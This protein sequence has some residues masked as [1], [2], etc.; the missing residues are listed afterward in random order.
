[1]FEYVTPE[2]VE[3]SLKAMAKLDIILIPKKTAFLRTVVYI[4]DS[5]SRRAVVDNGSGDNLLALFT[6]S[7]AMLKGFDH[8]SEL[9]QFAADEWDNG[10]FQR[11]YAG[12]PKALS[13]LLSEDDIDNTTFCMWCCNGSSVWE[14]NEVSA[15][16]DDGGRDF[17]LGYV[18]QT[19]ES[20]CDWAKY[21]YEQEYDISIVEKIYSG[22]DITAEDML[23]LN[24]KCNTDEAV[25]EIADII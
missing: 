19:A 10:F 7:G 5:D 24:P 21:Y 15:D 8:E 16:D 12:A 4:N 11:V 2:I 18:H 6:E 9:N 25:N 17:L 13:S 14:Q 1:M 20:W 3:R 23:K 22:S